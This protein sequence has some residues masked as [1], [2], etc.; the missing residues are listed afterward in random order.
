LD[1]ST[2]YRFK[3]EFRLLA[4]LI[5]PGLVR[6]HELFSQ[7]NQW[8]FTMELVEGLDFIAFVC[9]DPLVGAAQALD[10]TDAGEPDRSTARDPGEGSSHDQASPRQP[11]TD[12][13]SGPHSARSDTTD[14]GVWIDLDATDPTGAIERRPGSTD[15]DP[16]V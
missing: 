15:V 12:A 11:P 4:D 5:H 14:A 7:A 3:N 16:D 1:A 6:I 10:L 13:D 9:P 8:F 2:L